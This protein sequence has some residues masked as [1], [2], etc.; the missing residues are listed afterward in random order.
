MPV[1]RLLESHQNNP[2]LNLISAFVR[3]LQEDFQNADGRPRLLSFLEALG[4]YENC[5]QEVEKIIE[6]ICTLKSNDMEEAIS[7]ILGHFNSIQLAEITLNHCE[8]DFAENLIFEDIN[9]RLEAVI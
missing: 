9:S 6:F 7:C 1:P 3:I 4:S 2:G 5:A 8:C